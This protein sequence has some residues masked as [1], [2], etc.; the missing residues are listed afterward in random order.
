[1]KLK[2]TEGRLHYARLKAKYVTRFQRS[3][4]ETLLKKH[5]GNMSACTKE[6]GVGRNNFYRLLRQHKIKPGPYRG[7]K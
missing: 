2:F 6:S 5:A 3:Y 4:I 1:M 7:V